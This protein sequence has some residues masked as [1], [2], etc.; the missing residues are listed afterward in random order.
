MY[1]FMK[2]TS[3]S[4]AQERDGRALQGALSILP[5]IRL[6]G[7]QGAHK[8]LEGKYDGLHSFKK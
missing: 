6:Q 3:E 1:Y 4:D 5:R 8:E 7:R 2:Q